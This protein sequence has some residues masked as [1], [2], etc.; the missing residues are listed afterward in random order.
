M[1]KKYYKR[2]HVPYKDHQIKVTNWWNFDFDTEA[3]LYLDDQLVA[4]N[5][6]TDMSPFEPMFHLRM[7]PKRLKKLRYFCME[8]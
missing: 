6:E 5:K 1:S 7:R 8:L 3:R 2:W 4:V